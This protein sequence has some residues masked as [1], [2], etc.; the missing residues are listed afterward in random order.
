MFWVFLYFIT[1]KCVVSLKK[2]YFLSNELESNRGNDIIYEPL[3][4]LSFC[5]KILKFLD[6]KIN[7]VK[8]RKSKK[9][10]EKLLLYNE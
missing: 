7:N 2:D 5:L 8:G 3:V 1:A 10:K 6:L 9:E 4:I